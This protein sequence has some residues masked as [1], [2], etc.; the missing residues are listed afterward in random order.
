MRSNEIEDA[1]RV[2]L[3]AVGVELLAVVPLGEL[4]A[5]YPSVVATH[6]PLNG[7]SLAAVLRCTRQGLFGS[8]DDCG[9]AWAVGHVR[10]R[11]EVIGRR[12]AASGVRVRGAPWL[13][14]LGQALP[15]GPRRACNDERQGT[16]LGDRATD[17][18]G[19]LLSYPEDPVRP[20]W[21]RSPYL[22]K[23]VRVLRKYQ[24]EGGRTPTQAALAAEIG[25][26]ERTVR[27]LMPRAEE[28]LR[29]DQPAT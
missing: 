23:L 8:Y 28:I 1:A 18:M 22:P 20:K 21:S 3:T 7:T 2:A 25:C 13:C 27:G 11:L 14:P 6:R 26:A 19:R 12:P 9:A 10:G 24:S 15:G 16:V 4:R 5:R 29:R 17:A